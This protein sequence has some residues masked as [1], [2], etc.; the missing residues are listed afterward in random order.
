MGCRSVS[1][2]PPGILLALASLKNGWEAGAPGTLDMAVGPLS[3]IVTHWSWVSRPTWQRD[4]CCPPHPGVCLL[5][6]LHN[7]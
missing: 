3:H 6:H 1:S 7:I 4:F 5:L 2:C